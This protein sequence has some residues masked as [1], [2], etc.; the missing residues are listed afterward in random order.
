MEKALIKRRLFNQFNPITQE[1]LLMLYGTLDSYIINSGND[2]VTDNKTK[3]RYLK[4]EEACMYYDMSLYVEGMDEKGL[5]FLGY[6][7]NEETCSLNAQD[8]PTNQEKLAQILFQLIA[9]E[10]NI[11]I[12]K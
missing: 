4:L 7:P 2:M 11:R 8:T 3:E 9:E 1:L 6:S 10:K 12:I 5:T